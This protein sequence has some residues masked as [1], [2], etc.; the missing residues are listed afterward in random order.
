L[1][2]LLEGVVPKRMNKRFSLPEKGSF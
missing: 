1:N 2:M